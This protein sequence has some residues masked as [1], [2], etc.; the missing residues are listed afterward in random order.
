MEKSWDWFLSG[1]W[2]LLSKLGYK[3]VWEGGNSISEV[4]L[5][6]RGLI[7][8]R[9]ESKQPSVTVVWFLINTV[10]PRL[11]D[12]HPKYHDLVFACWN[13]PKVGKVK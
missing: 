11:N 3:H 6:E 9:T 12:H 2:L 4:D 13:R 1:Y 5:L 8:Q 7:Q 10:E